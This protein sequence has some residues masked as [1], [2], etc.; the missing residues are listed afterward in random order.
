VFDWFESDVDFISYFTPT[1]SWKKGSITKKKNVNKKIKPIFFEGLIENSS[2]NWFE[3]QYNEIGAVSSNTFDTSLGRPKLKTKRISK[4]KSN[5]DLTKKSILLNPRSTSI[6]RSMRFED[7]YNALIKI[8]NDLD[9]NIYVHSKNIKNED[10]NFIS[11]Q[12]KIDNRINVI[13]AKTLEEFL[14]DAYDTTI[15]ISV[16]SAIVHFR[17]GIQKPCIGIY[18]QF[19]TECRTKYYKHTHTFDIKSDC[20][21][22]PCFVHV[23]KNDEICEFQRELMESGEYDKRW[24]Y[25]PPCFTGVYN[26]TLIDQLVLN[27]K[28]YINKNI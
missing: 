13:H 17:E 14:L 16:D 10:V 11:K 26:N 24:Y 27:M 6:I 20:P 1:V 4:K 19:T 12:S 25:T 21:H 15:A 3:L 23:K 9:C 8:I 5:I 22:M 28:D 18:G 2:I 7:M